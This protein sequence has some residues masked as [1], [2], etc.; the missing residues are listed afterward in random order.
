MSN[1]TIGLLLLVV[2]GA[3]A[4]AAIGLSA[5]RWITL[6]DVSMGIHGWI[7]MGLGVLFTLGVGGGLMALTFYSSRHGYDDIET[8]GLPSADDFGEENE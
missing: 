1:W 8:S 5:W 4:L 7:A 6:N 2:F 3:I